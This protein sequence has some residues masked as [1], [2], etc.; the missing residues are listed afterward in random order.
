MNTYNYPLMRPICFHILFLIIVLSATAQEGVM[1]QGTMITRA[2]Y[3]EIP[4]YD[5]R[6]EIFE[7]VSLKGRKFTFIL[8]TGAP[9]CLSREIQ[10]QAQFPVLHIV[11][12]K[13][14]H[15][16]TDT[17]K[18][19]LVD[20]IRIGS[21]SFKDIPALVIDFKNSPIGCQE[22]DGII[23][24]NIVRFLTVQFDLS[25]K[26]IVLTDQPEKV[27]VAP[28][29]KR[30]P[31]FLDQQSN[32]F[33]KIIFND[34]V[35]DS[36]HFDS[37][38]G[39]LYDMNIR[40]AKALIAGTPT[41]SIHVFKGFGIPGQGI[42]GNAPQEEMFSIYTPFTLGNHLV[43]PAEIGTTQTASR[44][45]RE[46]FNYGKLTL[47]YRNKQYLF[48]TFPIRISPLRSNFGF[49]IITEHN[50]VVLS[51]VWENTKA[52]KKGLTTGTEVLAINGKTF[53][54]KNACTISDLLKP[55]FLQQKIRLTILKNNR[56][57][58]IRLKKIKTRLSP[59]N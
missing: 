10:D 28:S 33:T 11:P 56:T 32:A 49:E 53:Q 59:H 20:T 18:I 6:E 8:D 37:G 45:G 15:N 22:I 48:E 27:L 44:V 3:H 40:T 51:V 21:L 34:L 2:V 19:V 4:I 35:T 16:N 1:N 52:E 47:D 24:S 13:D 41:Q 26:K 43:N 23:G 36:A 30:Y 39:K 46:L 12:L 17:I 14:A 25:Q 55:A 31:L 29:A 50:K 38:M 42:L 57:H 7:K 58:T 54:N 9:L 5:T